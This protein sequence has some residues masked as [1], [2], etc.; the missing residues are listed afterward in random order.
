MTDDP[1]KDWEVSLPP[2][3]A[4]AKPKGPRHTWTD[5]G[6]R[7]GRCARCGLVR[8]REQPSRGARSVYGSFPITRYFAGGA[9]TERRPPCIGKDSYQQPLFPDGDQTAD[10]RSTVST[11]VHE[12]EFV[13]AKP[14]PPNAPIKGQK[15]IP[16]IGTLPKPRVFQI[17]VGNMPDG[18]DVCLEIVDDQFIFAS[19]YRW[20]I[21]LHA[22]RGVRKPGLSMINQYASVASVDRVVAGIMKALGKATP[23]LWI[24]A[25]KAGYRPGP[26]S[27]DVGEYVR[28]WEGTKAGWVFRERGSLGEVEDDGAG[29]G[30]E[31]DA[32]DEDD[33][34][35]DED[36]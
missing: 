29:E 2:P 30:G 14:T 19:E 23:G 25:K 8:E 21:F 24:V 10:P 18:V 7:Q 1:T 33:L 15:S 9:W 20:T 11:A 31:G 4:R 27:M 32:P 5:A 28:A 26:G 22:E 34:V 12:G 13:D 36:R 6:P 3:P 16:S 17:E 35:S